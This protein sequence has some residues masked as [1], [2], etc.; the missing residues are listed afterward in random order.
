MRVSV[1]ACLSY[2]ADALVSGPLP[3]CHM[4]FD[5]IGDLFTD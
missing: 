2:R 3:A 4:I 1:G 5:V